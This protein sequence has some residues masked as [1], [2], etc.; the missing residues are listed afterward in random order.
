MRKPRVGIVGGSGYVGTSLALSL[1]KAF[2]VK[3]VDKSPP[4]YGEHSDVEYRECNI[5]D[6]NKINEALEDVEL[7][8]HTAI[9][10]IPQINERARL[11]YEVNFLG[12]QNVCRVVDENPSIK[13]MIL[14]GTW[15]VFGE[16]G[17]SG[18]IDEAFG[19][20]PD[21]VEERAYLYAL[22]KIAQEV[23]LRYYDKMSGKIYGVVRMGTVLGEG[24]PEKTAANL[25]ISKGLKGEAM[26]PF[27]HSMYRPM[28]YV[29]INDVCKAF[30]AYASKILRGEIGKEDSGLA[31]IVNLCWPKPITII[32]LAHIIRDAIIQLTDEKM[33]PAIEI[34]DKGQP[35]LFKAADKER[36]KVDITKVR[37]LLGMKRLEDPKVPIR[38]II[39][40]VL[41]T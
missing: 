12:T 34:V 24:M 4:R 23:I 39:K 1:S 26:T 18:I 6:Y 25:F 2:A 28:L 30:E 14:A 21:K 5:E 35:L 3:V 17:L 7:V 8:I 29:D 11:G 22:S 13:G 36:M 40:K 20:R 19:F 16:E 41:E 37:R 15:H 33:R 38:R 31:H 9:I 10:Q 27:R 32:E